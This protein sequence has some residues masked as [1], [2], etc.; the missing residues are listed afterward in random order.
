MLWERKKIPPW[1]TKLKT[2][3]YRLHKEK[4]FWAEVKHLSWRIEDKK[5][6]SRR[7]RQQRGFGTKKQVQ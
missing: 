7:R 4:R 6:T 2:E 5:R 1:G 3:I